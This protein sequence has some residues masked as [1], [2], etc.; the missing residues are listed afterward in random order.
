SLFLEDGVIARTKDRGEGERVYQA[1]GDD[2]HKFLRCPVVVLVNGETTGGGELIAAAL[3]DHKRAAVAGQ[4]TRGKGSIQSPVPR[5]ALLR[6]GGG[7]DGT[8]ELKLTTGTFVRPNGKGLNR[9]ADS[10]PSDDRV[11]RPDPDPGLP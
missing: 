8:L 10:K 3:Q 6:E 4:R 9:L 5:L 7:F 1:Q 11:V 2:E